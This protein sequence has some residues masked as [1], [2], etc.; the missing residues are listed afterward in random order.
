MEDKEIIEN[1]FRDENSE[2]ENAKQRANDILSRIQEVE[3]EQ[4]QEFLKNCSININLALIGEN[5]DFI[6]MAVNEA[7]DFLNS[8]ESYRIK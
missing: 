3:D 4:Q 5:A 7:E 8:L 2:L 1:F 6:N